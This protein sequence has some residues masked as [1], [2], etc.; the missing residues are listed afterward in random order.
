MEKKLKKVQRGAAFGFVVLKIL[1][2]LLI[3]LAL[4]VVIALVVSALYDVNK[5]P[6]DNV[7]NGFLTLDFSKF[8]ITGL[9][10][11]GELIQDGV[12]KVE[13]TDLKLVIVMLLSA[14][15]LVLAAVYVLLLVAGNLFKHIKAEDTPFTRGNA[16]RLRL[17]GALFIAFWLCGMVLSY[18]LGSQIVRQLALPT[19]R[20][21]IAVN[22][23]PL[24]IGL[25][26][27]FLAA[28]FTFGRT[29]GEALS[30]L[31]PAPEPE[32]EPEPAYEPPAAPVTL[33]EPEPAYEPPTAPVILPEPEP[34]ADAEAEPAE[35]P[36]AEPAEL[37]VDLPPKPAQVFEP[38]AE[39]APLEAYEPPVEP[40]A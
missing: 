21:S 17:L 40:E 30:A 37:P 20:V 15:L 25:V 39:E 18:F 6:L 36:V 11:V 8:G 27:F 9:P 38:M 31:T 19:D 32:P 3:I 13:L 29:Q 35:E 5:L 22:L 2:I 10:K 28:V 24:G 4:V 1:R 12:L 16:R 7:E 26:F 23:V 14:L 33:P 34:A